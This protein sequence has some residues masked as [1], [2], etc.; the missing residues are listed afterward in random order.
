MGPLHPKT[1][2]KP[3]TS[4][5]AA[6]KDHSKAD[7][8]SGSSGVTTRSKD[9]QSPNVDY[10]HPQTP[11]WVL[12]FTS[13]IHSMQ[14]QINSITET[15]KALEAKINSLDEA[16]R[17]LQEALL[18]IESL[19]SQLAHATAQASQQPPANMEDTISTNTT[20]QR[21]LV[22]TSQGSSA[23]KW[24]STGPTFSSVVQRVTPEVHP[25]TTKPVPR[26]RLSSR[27]IA[28][29][30]RTFTHPSADQGFQ[31]LYFPIARKIPIREMRTNLTDL[32]LEN[33]RLV[34][35]HFPD[36][37]V[38]AV[39]VHND[40]AS[41]ALSILQKKKVSPEPNFD[42][43]SHTILR[44]PKFKNLDEAS[45][46]AKILEI[47]YTRSLNI[48]Q[49]LRSPVNIAVAREFTRQG[50]IQEEDLTELIQRNTAPTNNILRTNNE[51][52]TTPS[53]S[54]SMK[55]PHHLY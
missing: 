13:Q 31:Y 1:T 21:P 50:W 2:T 30:A 42:P 43:L 49:R 40:Y 6:L 28:S 7:K 35:V 15:N 11:E 19:R 47:H 52:E 12:N 29:I 4:P 18:E 45:R 3:N 37:N 44:D 20:D 33:S 46:S 16:E 38:V 17:R 34:N 10:L 25:R 55:P 9:A 5:I 54:T 14:N 8:V 51:Q 22:P 36:S 32:G 39:L 27:K 41:E 26:K 53:A 24:A 23:S 48:V